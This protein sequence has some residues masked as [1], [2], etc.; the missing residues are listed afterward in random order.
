MPYYI[1]MDLIQIQND[2]Q[3]SF[4]LST[5]QNLDYKPINEYKWHQNVHFWKLFNLIFLKIIFIFA[6]RLYSSS[7]NLAP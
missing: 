4:P 2:H 6:T 3:R 7:P 5:S 1:N